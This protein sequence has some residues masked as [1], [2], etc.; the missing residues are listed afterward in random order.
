MALLRKNEI[1][2]LNRRVILLFA[3]K[4]EEYAR[5]YIFIGDLK[6]A[7]LESYLIRSKTDDGLFDDGLFNDGLFGDEIELVCWLDE[8]DYRKVSVKIEDFMKFVEGVV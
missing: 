7:V 2:Q 3:E 5:K 8:G 1:V 6:S 4:L